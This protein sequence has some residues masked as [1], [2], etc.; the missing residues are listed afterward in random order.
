MKNQITDENIL[1][2]V[3]GGSLFTDTLQ[4]FDVY[5]DR[6]QYEEAKALYNELAD[7]FSEK[8]KQMFRDTYKVF[9]GEDL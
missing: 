8:Q 9:T 4:E 2:K 1:E 7:K 6:G 5:L 3:S